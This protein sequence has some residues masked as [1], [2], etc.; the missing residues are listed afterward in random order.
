MPLYVPASASGIPSGA[1]FPISP[2]ENDFYH[3]TDRDLTYFYDGTRWLTSQLFYLEYNNYANLTVDAAYPALVPHLTTYDVQLVS[4]DTYIYRDAAGEW[5]LE[6][7]RVSSAGVA[8]LI[9]TVDGSA[10]ASATFITRTRSLSTILSNST[11]SVVR[12]FANEI[13]GTANFN[14]SASLNYRLIG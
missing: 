2:L 13:S 6:L 12:I 11:T 8:T 5:D 1:A 14:F 9:D 7:Y 4:W 3:R 10:D